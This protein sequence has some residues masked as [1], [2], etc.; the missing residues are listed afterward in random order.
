MPLPIAGIA[1]F[2]V[3]WIAQRKGKNTFE[4]ILWGFYAGLP[5]VLFAWLT[6]PYGG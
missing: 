5:F 4:V 1:A 2:S 6:S 3:S